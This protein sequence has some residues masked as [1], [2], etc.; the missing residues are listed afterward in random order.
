M[1]RDSIVKGIL[2]SYTA[3]VILLVIY[4]PLIVLI[5]FSFNDSTI[6]G[7]P[8]KGFTLKWYAEI[9]KN[10]VLV[11]S[12]INSVVV[13]AVVTVISLVVG[14]LAARGMTKFH[15]RLKSLF[16]GYVSI[17]FVMPWMLIGVALLLFFNLIKMP[18]S[19]FTVIISHISFDIPL[20]AVLISSRLSKFDYSVEEAS[21]DLGSTPFQSFFLVTLPI[22]APSLISAG[23]FSFS[24]SFDAFYI[25]H[26]VSGSQVFFPTWIWSA[27]RYPNKLP[28]INAVS[29]LILVVEIIIITVAEIIRMKDEDASEALFM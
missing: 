7:L 15:Y 23:I 2:G 8:W 5:V 17:P 3:V 21:R 29:A 13:A 1:K 12:L 28:L 22:I 4:L 27:L 10:D 20:V 14:F 26:F 25:T 18:L 24:W 19:L 9:G 6:S 16:T 11:S